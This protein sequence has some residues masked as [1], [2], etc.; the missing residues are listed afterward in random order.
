VPIIGQAKHVI[1]LGDTIQ[2]EP[3]IEDE[4]AYHGGLGVSILQRMIDAGKLHYLHRL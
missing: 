2:L 3:H 1:F 4:H